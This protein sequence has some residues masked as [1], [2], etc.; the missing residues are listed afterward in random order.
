M[1]IRKAPVPEGPV[2]SDISSTDSESH[3]SSCSS[4]SYAEEQPKMSRT[5]RR[6][7]DNSSTPIST[8]VTRTMS[9]NRLDCSEAPPAIQST[10]M[11]RTRSSTGSLKSP[12]NKA[13]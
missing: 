9:R 3:S 11:M 1:S 8:R 10:S 6:V 13:Y 4:L 5:P 7:S 2:P 12:R